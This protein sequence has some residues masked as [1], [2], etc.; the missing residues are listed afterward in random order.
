ML[1]LNS[2][3]V[4]DRLNIKERTKSVKQAPRSFKPELEV[5]IKQEIHKLL[6]VGFIKPIQH[7]T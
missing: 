6:D 7:Q 2:Q 5:Q 1:A 3:L 4:T